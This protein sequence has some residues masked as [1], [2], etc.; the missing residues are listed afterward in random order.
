[1]ID[2]KERVGKAADYLKQAQGLDLADKVEGPARKNAL[3]WAHAWLELA[4]AE[5]IQ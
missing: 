1:V 4:R 5:V 2:G 3:E